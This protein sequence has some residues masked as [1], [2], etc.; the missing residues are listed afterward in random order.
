MAV[1]FQLASNQLEIWHDQSAYPESPLYNIGGTLIINGKINYK[2]LNKALQLLIDENDAF[3]LTICKQSP[4]TQKLLED[5]LRYLREDFSDSDS[6][7]HKKI[8]T[9]KI[10]DDDDDDDEHL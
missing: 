6:F 5:L 10:D 7:W 3:R 8:L 4:A 9:M 1:F 2:T